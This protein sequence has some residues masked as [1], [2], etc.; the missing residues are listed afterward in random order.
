VR[1]PFG[2][3]IN[4]VILTSIENLDVPGVLRALASAVLSRLKHYDENLGYGDE[5]AYK[6][7][8][9]HDDEKRRRLLRAILPLLSDPDRDWVRLITSR[10]PLVMSRDLPWMIERFFTARSTQMK[11]LW[12]RLIRGTYD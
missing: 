4:G 1:D 6:G 2:K 12:L 7:R 11:Q 5:L 3:V 8:L 9:T 10:I